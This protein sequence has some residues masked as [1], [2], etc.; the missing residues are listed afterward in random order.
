MTSIKD[1]LKV[2]PFQ[3]TAG[4]KAPCYLVWFDVRQ[5][6]WCAC[7]VVTHHVCLCCVSVCQ[8]L[9]LCVWDGEVS[10]YCHDCYCFCGIWGTAFGEVESVY[11][12]VDIFVRVSSYS[13][14]PYILCA[15]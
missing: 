3:N 12:P 8:S 4:S 10:F 13:K 15:S 9:S 7:G 1:I 11:K 14:S 2:L 6:H 5:P